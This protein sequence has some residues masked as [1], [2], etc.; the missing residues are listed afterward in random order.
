MFPHLS[1]ARTIPMRLCHTLYES[2][3]RLHGDSLILYL[4]SQRSRAKLPMLLSISVSNL[5]FPRLRL[6]TVCFSSSAVALPWLLGERNIWTELHLQP[7]LQSKPWRLE[8]KWLR[9]CTRSLRRGG[10]IIKRKR[11]EGRHTRCFG[12]RPRVLLR[13]AG[14]LDSYDNDYAHTPDNDKK[15]I[16][17]RA[18]SY[19]SDPVADYINSASWYTPANN[20]LFS[21]CDPYQ[22]RAATN[23]ESKWYKYI[24]KYIWQEYVN[25]TKTNYRSLVIYL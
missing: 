3:R 18:E 14:S 11:G 22:L 2:V 17:G 19:R 4:L 25:I 9:I 23:R 6:A 21:F 13:D 20:I 16:S 10:G 8:I 24:S 1:L 15:N 7:R 5:W 12:E